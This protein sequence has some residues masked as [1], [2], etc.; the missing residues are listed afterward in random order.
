LIGIPIAQVVVD[1]ELGIR[2]LEIW[3]GHFERHH[4]ATSKRLRSSGPSLQ[5]H[6]TQRNA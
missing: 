4:I 6:R 1:R 3:N 2:R 5:A